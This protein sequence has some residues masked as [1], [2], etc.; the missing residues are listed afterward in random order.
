M[1][2]LWGTSLQ[3]VVGA[4]VAKFLRELDYHDHV[5]RAFDNEPVLAAGMRVAHTIRAGQGPETVLRPGQMYGKSR[6][7]RA[8]KSIQTARSQ[9]EF[10][11]GAPG[12]Q[13]GHQVPC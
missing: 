4:A 1:W 7:C 8:E 12:G 10:F 3:S 2:N 6:T 5:E 13:G 9:N 11:D